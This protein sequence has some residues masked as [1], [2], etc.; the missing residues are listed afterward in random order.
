[1]QL[2]QLASD[3]GEECV[4]VCIFFLK[5]LALTGAMVVMM[6]SCVSRDPPFRDPLI[7]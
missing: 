6:L 5:R 2:Q 7:R 1:M 4:N 3:K